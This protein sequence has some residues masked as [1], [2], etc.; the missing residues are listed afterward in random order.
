MICESCQLEMDVLSQLQA[1][2]PWE[3]SAGHLAV[4]QGCSWLPYSPG[5]WGKAGKLPSEERATLR[6]NTLCFSVSCPMSSH[7]VPSHFWETQGSW[8]TS[9]DPFLHG[10]QL[11]CKHGPTRQ[12]LCSG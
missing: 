7:P 1:M 2:S 3:G 8:R 4:A 5:F 9:Q 10:Q 6:S 11:S 12:V